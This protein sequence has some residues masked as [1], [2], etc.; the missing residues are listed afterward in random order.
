MKEENGNQN[1]QSLQPSTS[2]QMS[3]KSKKGKE[4]VETV[5]QKEETVQPKKFQLPD[6]EEGLWTMDFDGALGKD[7]A[8][9]K[10]WIRSAIH[11]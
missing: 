9:I 4:Q 5:G 6:D 7:G 11:Q 3:V 8:G 1:S 2:K 10:I